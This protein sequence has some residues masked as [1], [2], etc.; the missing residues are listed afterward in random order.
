M[1][2]GQ[3][4]QPLTRRKEILMVYPKF[5]PSFWGFGYIKDIGGFEAVQPPLGLGVLASLT[6]R[7]FDVEIV[8]ENIEE[9]NFATECDLVAMSGMVI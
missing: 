4:V 1:G 8:D 3:M 2:D 5:P 6:P 7:D 9:I